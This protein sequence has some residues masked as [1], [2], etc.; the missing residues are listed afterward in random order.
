V[1][2]ALVGAYGAGKT[3]LA[4]ALA[5]VLGLPRVQGSPMDHPL[6]GNGRT[7]A[8]CTPGELLQLTVRRYV[9]RVVAETA[10]NGGFISDG[11]TVHEWVYAKVRLVA[12]SFPD[13]EDALVTWP[14]MEDTRLYEEVA[15]QLGLL[16]REH[17]A[18][19]YDVVVHLPV[20]FGLRDTA[21][22]VSAEFRAIS[23][24]LITA[25]FRGTG[26]PFHVVSGSVADRVAAV[27]DITGT[28]SD[29][30]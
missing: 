6:G 9:E 22:P 7:I 1:R 16:M 8:N 21:P 11:S 20:E 19:R 14:R 30:D 23:D 26:I 13:R 29:N 12:G 24:R 5:P 28:Y 27:L 15:D 17:A 2:L 18:S 10:A 25:F 3:T 4:N